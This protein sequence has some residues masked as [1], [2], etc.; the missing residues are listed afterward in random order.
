MKRAGFV[1][2]IGAPNVGKS[3]LV[4][5]LV[6]RKVSI[7]TRKAQTTRFPVRG[8]AVVGETQLVL[9]DTP[10]IFAPRRSLD[11]AMVRSAWSGAQDAD[12]VVHLLD[13]RAHARMAAGGAGRGTTAPSP[14]TRPSARSSPPLVG[15]PSSRST[16]PISSG[17]PTFCPSSSACG[18]ARATR[19][20]S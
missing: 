2:V 16:R 13:A 12:A 5:R 14:R 19:R 8:V 4:N 11:R 15:R 17:S 6:G 3:T 10:G 18:N 9:V 7:A 1:A 20:S